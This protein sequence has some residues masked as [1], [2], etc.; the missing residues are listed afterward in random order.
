MVIEAN[1]ELYLDTDYT[2]DLSSVGF[3]LFCL[4]CGVIIDY[5]S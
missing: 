3:L 5:K 4:I 1:D 2:N